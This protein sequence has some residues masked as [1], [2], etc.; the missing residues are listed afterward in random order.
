MITVEDSA[1]VRIHRANVV[2]WI[3][4]SHE[5]RVD[6]TPWA[7]VPSLIIKILSIIEHARHFATVVIEVGMK[8]FE[9]WRHKH[10]T[11][12]QVWRRYT[13]CHGGSR[14]WHLGIN[15]SGITAVLF[16]IKT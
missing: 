5:V 11:I 9:M 15:G 10:R 8:L 2:L 14:T 4:S 13:P 12:E 6:V 16:T 3:T 1:G 7:N